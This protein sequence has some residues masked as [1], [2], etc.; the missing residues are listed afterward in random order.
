MISGGGNR[1]DLKPYRPQEGV[2]GSHKGTSRALNIRNP[3]PG[4][5]YGWGR[6]EGGY[7]QRKAN[8]GWRVVPPDSPERK[9]L[10]EDL[11]Q[12][13]ALDGTQARK[14]VVLLYIL[15]KDYAPIQRD[16]RRLAQE[17]VAGS[18]EAFLAKSEP[19]DKRFGD[20][21]DGPVYY[22]APGHRTRIEGR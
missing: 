16:K 22:R 9:G 11:H 15:E 13:Q 3:V 17:A 12:A 21:A 14:D 5:L 2:Y 1:E 18:T 6:R 7:L 20:S 4:R 19:L 8:D 10:E